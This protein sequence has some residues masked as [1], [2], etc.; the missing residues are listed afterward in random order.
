[1]E[2]EGEGELKG[3]WGFLGWEFFW[4]VVEKKTLGLNSDVVR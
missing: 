2:I 3:F 1:M 4:K